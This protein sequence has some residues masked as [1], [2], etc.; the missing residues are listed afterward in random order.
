MVSRNLP[1]PTKFLEMNAEILENLP[2]SGMP[3]W[4]NGRELV[5]GFPITSTELSFFLSL[6]ASGT[7]HEQLVEGKRMEKKWKVEGKKE[8]LDQEQKTEESSNSEINAEYIDQGESDFY[9]KGVI[10]Q[11]SFE[12]DDLEWMVGFAPLADCLQFG[13]KWIDSLEDATPYNLY[14]WDFRFYY[15]VQ[16]HK[17]RHPTEK[18]IDRYRKERNRHDSNALPSPR[19]SEKRWKT[20]SGM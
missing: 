7:S 9:R 1:D 20:S 19:K 15:L 6:P 17:I 3:R 2:E 18:E 10:M 13:E 11:V 4:G 5:P 8:E 16:E 14:R 12:S